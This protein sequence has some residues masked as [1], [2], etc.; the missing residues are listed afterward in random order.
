[1]SDPFTAFWAPL[2]VGLILFLLAE[3]VRLW[4]TAVGARPPRPP[5]IISLMGR[6][7]AL[8]ARAIDDGRFDQAYIERSFRPLSKAREK[9]DDLTAQALDLFEVGEE[10]VAFW[11]AAEFYAGWYSPFEWLTAT[12]TPREPR[13]SGEPLLSTNDLT[14]G[15]SPARPEELASWAQVRW[16][17]DRGNSRGPRYGDLW[18]PG[19]KTRHAVVIPNSD[20]NVDMLRPFILYLPNPSGGPFKPPSKREAARLK[21]RYERTNEQY[22]TR[23]SL[24]IDEQYV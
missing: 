2:A 17:W 4:W 18:S 20:V 7:V 21:R 10:V 12:R 23:R 14:P 11:T 19:D 22:E 15:W 1:M 8:Q 24:L 6:A 16:P 3:T 9:Y 13:E 5:A